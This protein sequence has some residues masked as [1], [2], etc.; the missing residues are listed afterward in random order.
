MCGLCGAFALDPEQPIDRAALEAMTRSLAHRGPDGERIAH[1]PGFALGFRRLAILDP[2]ERGMQPTSTQDGAITSVLNGEIY[3]YPELRADLE[4]HG[5]QLRSG[6]DAEII[7][8]LYARHGPAFVERLRGMFAVAVVDTRD[9]RLVLARDR[10]GKKPL[11]VARREGRIEFASEPKALLAAS[12]SAVEPDPAGLVRFL[13][14]GYVPGPGS[15]FRGLERVQPGERWVVDRSGVRVERYWSLPEPAPRARVELRTLVDQFDHLL[16]QATTERLASDV[17]LGVLLSGGIDSGLVLAKAAKAARRPLEAFTIAFADK[18]HDERALAA[19]T[20][21]HLGVRLHVL[22]AQPIPP[23]SLLDIARTWD[24][25][26]GDASAYPTALVAKL[27]RAQVTVALSGDGGDEAFAGYRRHRALALARRIDRFVPRALRSLLA[28]AVGESANGVGGRSG[29]GAFRRFATA[30][31]LRGDAERQIYWSTYFRTRVRERLLHPELREA[32]DPDAEAAAEFERQPGGVVERALR[33]DQ[34]RYLP[35]DLLVKMDTASMAVG[36]EVRSPLLDHRIVEFAATLPSHL[37]DGS[38]DTKPL[39]RALA[40]RLLPPEVATARKR[41]FGVPLAA[42]LRGPF[43]GVARRVLL[44]ERMTRR[45]VFAPGALR[46][47]LERHATGREDWSQYIWLA[48]VL[49]L[50]FRRFV[51][52]DLSLD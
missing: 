35:D 32:A 21:K 44:S 37:R 13:C 31:G 20:A 34:A 41:G 6:C 7:P 3:N 29:F 50:W 4:A 22:E 33:F 28:R 19:R 5:V 16:A 14:F 43:A 47:V 15:A 52:R 36:L 12:P 18:A 23:E 11:Y 51:D 45:R 27:A 24:E 49:E 46:D 1:G 8:H 38:G 17:P 9:H 26:F 42:W 10:L 25:P 2:S 30:L 48:L 39:L 40:A